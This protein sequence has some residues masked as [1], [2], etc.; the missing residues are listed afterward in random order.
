MGK[1]TTARGFSNIAWV[2][3]W[4]KRDVEENLPLEDSLAVVLDGPPT[5]LR[6]TLEAPEF[7]ILSGGL[8]VSPPHD[9]R[10]VK[11]L[12]EALGST[13]NVQIE[14]SAGLPWGGG[15]AQ[16][17][18]TFAALA[19]ALEK[20]IGAPRSEVIRWAR[21]GSGSAVRSLAPGFVR[22]HA[23]PEST[24]PTGLEVE[25]CFGPDHWP[26]LR[27]LLVQLTAQHKTVGSTEGML[28]SAQT[29]PLFDA[30]REASRRVVPAFL[31]ALRVRD[32]GAL[33]RLTQEHCEGMHEVCQTSVP[34]IRYRSRESL[35]VVSLV[36]DLSSHLPVFYT[37]D[38]GPNPVLFTLDS[39]VPRV[40]EEVSRRFP[41]SVLRVHRPGP[42]AS[43]LEETS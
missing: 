26:S 23:H 15:F 40:L 36:Q 29:S 3:Y 17:A 10:F 8:C 9:A 33:A 39:A 30:W 31:E 4:G 19:V 34:S 1:W 5:T 6:L 43:A 7:R 14:L 11:V 20:A 35:A 37:F 42:A 22:W 24:S 18:A 41:D 25:S 38:A 12:K 16:S 32:F 27:V 2:K 21:L 28:R 13:R